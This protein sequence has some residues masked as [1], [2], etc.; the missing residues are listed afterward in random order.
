M[1]LVFNEVGLDVKTTRKIINQKLNGNWEE[2]YLFYWN[3]Y[4]IFDEH[5]KFDTMLV[6]TGEKKFRPDDEF[7]ISGL[8]GVCGY[9][10]DM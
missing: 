4:G 7:G 2:F 6:L 9:G 10:N 3:L 5:M 8:G 1:P